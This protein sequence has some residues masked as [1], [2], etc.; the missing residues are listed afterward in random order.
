MESEP[1]GRAVCGKTSTRSIGKEVNPI[2]E[3]F[4]YLVSH[5]FGRA[6][7]DIIKAMIY[8]GGSKGLRRIEMNRHRRARGVMI[9]AMTPEQKWE[10]EQTSLW[11][12]LHS[13]F[14]R[15]EWIIYDDLPEKLKES[16]APFDEEYLYPHP[17]LT[18]GV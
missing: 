5:A 12:K 10:R 9:R 17:H 6:F 2:Y 1:A 13:I 16:I 4:R 18:T 11:W 14:N 8:T 3:A 7:F 15:R